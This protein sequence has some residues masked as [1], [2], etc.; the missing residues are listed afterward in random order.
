[1]FTCQR[2]RE[3]RYDIY[4]LNSYLKSHVHYV[5]LLDIVKKY[6]HT[7]YSFGL[8]QGKKNAT[9]RI[10]K[11]TYSEQNTCPICFST[12]LDIQ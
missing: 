7:R 10:L 6:T 11:S 1:M 8:F 2:Q 9:Q 3:G 5:N 4:C 12:Q